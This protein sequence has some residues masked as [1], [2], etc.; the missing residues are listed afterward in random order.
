MR[1]ISIKGS[2]GDGSLKIKSLRSEGDGLS[3]NDLLRIA[4][5]LTHSEFWGRIDE[6]LANWFTAD[7]FNMRTKDGLLFNVKE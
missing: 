2:I 7:G 1:V 6:S 3:S 4:N 5:L